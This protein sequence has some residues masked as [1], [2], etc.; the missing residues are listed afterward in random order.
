MVSLAAAVSASVL[1]E[2]RPG[3]DLALGPKTVLLPTGPA[4]VSLRG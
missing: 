1:P 3:A 4:A 2:V